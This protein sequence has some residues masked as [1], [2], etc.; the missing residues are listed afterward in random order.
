MAAPD[1]GTDG[2]VVR[3]HRAI[4]SDEAPRSRRVR[5]RR[6]LEPKERVQGLVRGRLVPPDRAP[7][8]EAACVAD[9]RRVLA[10][11]A[12]GRAERPGV[13]EA[14]TDGVDAAIQDR[15]V[16]LR[17][18]G[19]RRAAPRGGMGERA[20]GRPGR[21]VAG[22]GV[23]PPGFLGGPAVRRS[24]E[25]EDGDGRRSVG[26]RVARTGARAGHAD[27]A[28]AVQRVVVFEGRGVESH[29]E[30]AAEQ[31]GPVS[32]RR[33]REAEAAP[34]GRGATRVPVG[35]SVRGRIVRPGLHHAGDKGLAEHDVPQGGG[36]IDKGIVD[37]LRWR[38][39]RGD[40]GP[41]ARRDIEFPGVRHEVRVVVPT[42]HDDDLLD[43]IIR[44]SRGL[45]RGGLR[46]GRD[47]CP[48]VRRVV[49]LPRLVAVRVTSEQDREVVP[50]VERRGGSFEESGVR[51]GILVLPVCDVL[52]ELHP[53]RDAGPDDL[54]ARER[55]PGFVEVR[56]RCPRTGGG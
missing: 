38:G 50:R 29:Q 35:P 28:P 26:H 21:H 42:E 4:G 8:R 1:R 2:R 13:A 17:V 54:R 33:V 36:V 51:P 40:R 32:V 14:R 10:R 55:G 46:G 39:R 44:E 37:H 30:R 18:I 3:R 7:H 25:E 23:V 16:V 19:H 24:S 6:E 41:R 31:D 48:R 9:G 52:Q 11:G 12:I 15:H 43:R 53:R 34:R 56:V 5:A 47:L 22:R 45:T 49:V 27:L 20:D